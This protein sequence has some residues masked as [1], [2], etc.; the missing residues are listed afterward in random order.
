M[1][2]PA[3]P[4]VHLG[5][6]M[7]SFVLLGLFSF[8]LYTLWYSNQFRVP[9]A[10]V[11]GLQNITSES[12]NTVLG[13]SGTPV[14]T[15]DAGNLEQV[16]KAEFQE[17]SAAQAHI[18]L[19]NSVVITVTERVPVLIWLQ[20]ERTNLVDENGI[21]FPLRMEN[22]S[23]VLPVIEA[24]INPPAP[25]GQLADSLITEAV[26]TFDLGTFSAL[27]AGENMQES[28]SRPLLTRDMVAAV[29]LM[30][31]NAPPEA[32]LLYTEEHGLVWK[33]KRGWSVY[34]GAPQD[35]EM[36]LKVYRAILDHTKVQDTRPELISVEF[37]SA[38]YY[39]IAG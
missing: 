33:D 2:L 15:L 30:A 22:E 34:F 18:A 17:F 13:I 28:S 9:A 8:G 6:R 21:T 35:M 16:L 4:Q 14:F 27:E 32:L 20:D 29:L 5:W 12:V 23:L 31:K 1:R 25:P 37:I 7:L 10:R 19:P 36:K 3:L 38:P 39:R 24:E 11:V 26:P